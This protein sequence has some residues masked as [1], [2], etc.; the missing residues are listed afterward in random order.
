MSDKRLIFDTAYRTLSI[1]VDT[2][3]KLRD[4]IDERFVAVV[5]AIAA[6]RGRVVVTGIGKSALVGQKIAATFNSTGTPALFM[7]AADAIHGDLGMIQQGDIVLALSKSGET[8]E[9]RALLPLLRHHAHPVIAVVSKLD[10]FLSKQAKY[11]LYTPVAKEADP[12]NLAPTASALAQMAM[13]D[14]LASALLALRGFGPK[15][16]AQLHPGGSLGKQLYLTLADLGCRNACPQ[17]LPS[18]DLQTV[19][20]EMTSKR[21]GATAVVDVKNQLLGIITDGDLRRAIGAGFEVLRLSAKQLMTPQPRT[22][23]QNQL[24]V[25]G[26]ALLEKHNITQLLLSDDE[27]KYVGMVH[28]H[29]FVREGI[30]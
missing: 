9:M 21:L 4:S 5:K 28:L 17:V 22:L 20:V 29:D 7:H 19:V 25:E 23:S 26:L 15:D 30:V 1:E 27:G 18:A 12:H 13:G 3:A 2:L 14:A 8:A 24:A 6:C 11:T 10:S 16:F